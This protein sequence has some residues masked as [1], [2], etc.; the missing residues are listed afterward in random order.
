MIEKKKLMSKKP[1]NHWLG[2]LYDYNQSEENNL[3]E[4]NYIIR[5]IA[6]AKNVGKF[7]R[8]LGEKKIIN[9]IDYLDNRKN[10]ACLFRYCPECGEKINWKRLQKRLREAV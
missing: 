7:Q 2:Y 4:D 10:Y 5:C 6:V 1:C 8:F 9:S 3:Y